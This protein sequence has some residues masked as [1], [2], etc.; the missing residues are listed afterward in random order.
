MISCKRYFVIAVFATSNYPAASRIYA[1]SYISSCSMVLSSYASS[2]S[3]PLDTTGF[4][5]VALMSMA[6]DDT[7][8]AVK[9]KKY[10]KGDTLYYCEVLKLRNQDYRDHVFAVFGYS[11]IYQRKGRSK[12]RIK[13]ILNRER[14][15]L[16]KIFYANAV[17]VERNRVDISVKKYMKRLEKKYPTVRMWGVLDANAVL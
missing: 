2:V 3:A 11:H 12:L 17:K 16:S 10:K 1:G 14:N 5:T 6:D 9:P 7:D 4:H 8:I 15:Y 13:Y